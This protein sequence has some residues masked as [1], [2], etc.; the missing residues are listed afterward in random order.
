MKDIICILDDDNNYDVKVAMLDK[1]P[2][3]KAMPKIML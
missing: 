1:M 2:E 3:L